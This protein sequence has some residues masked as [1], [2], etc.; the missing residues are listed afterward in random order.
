MGSKLGQIMAL[1]LVLQVLVL[2]GR[3]SAGITYSIVQ[4][5]QYQVDLNNQV[6][7]YDLLGTITTDG[8]LGQLAPSNILSWQIS[9]TAEDNSRS[10]VWNSSDSTTSVEIV[11]QVNA[12][13]TTIEVPRFEVVVPNVFNRFSLN[14]L[15]LDQIIPNGT[16]HP[17]NKL[18]WYTGSFG[19]TPFLHEYFGFLSPRNAPLSAPWISQ[20]GIFRPLF[21]PDTTGP[22]IVAT[23]VPEPSSAILFGL[24]VGVG[25]CR[26]RRNR[27]AN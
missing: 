20:D 22:I 18:S 4:Y 19:T 7:K 5:P 21:L 14:G 6:T 10:V 15:L 27:S 9:S 24:A 26:I 13:P 16:G 11:G 23:A 8:T 12:T 2:S 17:Q 25:I 1:A 3:A